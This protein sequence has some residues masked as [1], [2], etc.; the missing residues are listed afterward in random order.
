M[1]TTL[2]IASPVSNPPPHTA[3]IED[4][5]HFAPLRTLDEEALSAL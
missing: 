1:A 3:T 2:H 5:L 4:M